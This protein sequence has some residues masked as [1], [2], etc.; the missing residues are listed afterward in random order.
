MKLL[1]YWITI[2]KVLYFNSITVSNL[3]LALPKGIP[4]STQDFQ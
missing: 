2:G 4:H 3:T 1:I